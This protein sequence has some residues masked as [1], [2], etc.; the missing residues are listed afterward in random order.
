[1]LELHDKILHGLG[2]KETNEDSVFV[3]TDEK[4]IPK[5]DQKSSDKISLT[6]LPDIV[7]YSIEPKDE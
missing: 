7:N 5:S 6:E 1:M 3:V 4:Y 2:Y